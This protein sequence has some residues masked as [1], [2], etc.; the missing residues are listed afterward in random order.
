[1]FKLRT[2]RNTGRG[3]ALVCVGLLAFLLARTCLPSLSRPASH[4]SAVRSRLAHDHR[5]YFDNA[6]SD[7]IIAPARAFQ[8]GLLV[9]VTSHLRTASAPI[10]EAVAFAVQYNRPPPLAWDLR[11]T[12]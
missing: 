1:M 9:N 4:V 5:S 6:G 10:I 7:S 12:S 8:P 2:I 3:S 11:K